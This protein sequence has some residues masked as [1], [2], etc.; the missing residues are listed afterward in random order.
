M[1][2]IVG[3]NVVQVAKNFDPDETPGCSA[4]HPDTSCA[5]WQTFVRDNGKSDML[6]YKEKCLNSS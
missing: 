1:S 5:Q 6:Q 4:S 2:L 3:E